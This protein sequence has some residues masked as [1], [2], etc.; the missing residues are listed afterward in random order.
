VEWQSIETAPDD[1]NPILC[2]DATTGEIR[3]GIRKLF[4]ANSGRYEWFRDDLNV[5][6]Q[7]WSLVPTH[8]MPLPQPPEPA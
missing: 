5:P 4:Y 7:T 2:C 1:G 6:G 8:W 3:V